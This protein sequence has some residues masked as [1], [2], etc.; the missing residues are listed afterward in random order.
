[1]NPGAEC[2]VFFHQRS[3]CRKHHNKLCRGRQTAA[4]PL[5][6][7]NDTNI[8]KSHAVLSPYDTVITKRLCARQVYETL[9]CLQDSTLWY[10]EF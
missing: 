3:S 8:T 9:K 1:M 7:T 2:S 10:F 5:I 6:R 4:D